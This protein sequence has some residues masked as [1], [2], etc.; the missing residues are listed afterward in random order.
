MACFSVDTCEPSIQWDLLNVVNGADVIMPAETETVQRTYIFV[1]VYLGLH[2]ALIVTAL[3]GLCGV[4]NSCLGRK[5]F[6]IFIAPWVFVWI[7]IIVLDV[8]ASVYF[9]IDTISAAVSAV[10]INH[11]RPN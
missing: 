4:N 6:P 2:A 5:S 1:F 9:V 10:T 7:A 11:L 8:L 3:Y